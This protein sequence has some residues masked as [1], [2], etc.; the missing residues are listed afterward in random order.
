MLLLSHR[1]PPDGVVGVERITQTLAAEL[2][3]RGDAVSIVTRREGPASPRMV[4]ERLP[5]GTPLYRLA[6][7]RVTVKRFLAYHEQLERLFTAALIEAAPDVVHVMHLMGLSPRFIGMA[8]DRG[9]AVV[10]SLQ[11]FHFACPL[12]QLR[13][14]SGELCDGPDGGRECARTCFAEEGPSARLRWGLRA[15]YYRR[16]LVTAERLVC[17]SRYVAA[18]FRAFGVDPARVRIVPNGVAIDPVDPA[19][20]A[21]STPKQRGILNL[22][23]LGSVVIHKGL[24]VILEALRGAGLDAVELRVLGPLAESGYVRR[25]RT[26]AAAIPG[27]KLRFYGPYATAELPYLLSDVDCVITPSEW[28]ETF[29]IVTREAFVLGIPVVVTRLGALPEAVTDGEN[30]FT[31]DPRRPEELA[32]IL[33]RLVDEGGLI[34]RLREGARK[35][36]VWTVG[37]HADAVRAVY[38]EALEDVARGDAARD[39]DAGEFA[40]LHEALLELGVGAP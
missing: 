39:G 5:D 18:Y 12:V 40:F 9:A 8:H 37:E 19:L 32:A 31:F 27:V 1:F 10:V 26:E 33:R 16:L 30:G 34:G 29:A 14:R 36:R 23:F 20:L 25:L 35:T 24:H 13:K 15:A 38:A 28:P 7:G 22:A 11:D 3:R 4:R 2:A 21:R 6:G 17:P